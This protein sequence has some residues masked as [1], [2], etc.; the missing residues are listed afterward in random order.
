MNNN[1]GCG[2]IKKIVNVIMTNENTKIKWRYE[3]KN[4]LIIYTYYLK[5]DFN[6]KL[7]N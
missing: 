5:F 3:Y 1:K 7:Y 2:I 6:F 4:K